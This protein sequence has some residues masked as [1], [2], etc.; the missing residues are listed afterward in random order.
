MNYR[1]KNTN[2]FITLILTHL[3]TL[4]RAAK[5]NFF[6]KNIDIIE[7]ANIQ[8][9]F[10][11]IDGITDHTH[12]LIDKTSNASYVLTKNTS[13][14]KQCPWC[15]NCSK[16][17]PKVHLSNIFRNVLV[18]VGFVKRKLIS[19]GFSQKSVEKRDLDSVS[20]NII[21]NAGVLSNYFGVASV[22]NIK[23]LKKS[24]NQAINAIRSSN[25]ANDIRTEHIVQEFEI[26]KKMQE[27]QIEIS[28]AHDFQIFAGLKLLLL[29]SRLK[30]MVLNLQ[31]TLLS[32]YQ[33]KDFILFSD[34]FDQAI[35]RQID[36]DK[37][38][39]LFRSNNISEL[40]K[41]PGHIRTQRDHFDLV[42][43]IEIPVI[44]YDEI[45]DVV[46][47]NHTSTTVRAYCP[48]DHYWVSIPL[49]KCSNYKENFY[50]GTRPCK[51]KNVYFPCYT[52]SNNIF[53]F[54]EDIECDINGD[55]KPRGQKEPP[56]ENITNVIRHGDRGTEGGRNSSEGKSKTLFLHNKDSLKCMDYIIEKTGP[57]KNITFKNSVLLNTRDLLMNNYSK[58]EYFHD[59]LEES[60][61]TIEQITNL[62]V[63]DSK[64][65]ETAFDRYLQA[66][67][68]ITD[69]IAILC[70]I[71]IFTFIIYKIGKCWCNRTKEIHPNTT[72]SSP[73]TVNINEGNKETVKSN[74][75]NNITAKVNATE[76]SCQ[77]ISENVSTGIQTD[78]SFLSGMTTLGTQTE[79]QEATKVIS[80]DTQTDLPEH[81]LK[82]PEKTDA[83]T[84]TQDSITNFGYSTNQ[85]NNLS[86]E[87][88]T[89]RLNS[90]PVN[91]S[92]TEPS[93]TTATI[94]EGANSIPEIN[95]G[96]LPG[97]SS[98]LIPEKNGENLMN[99]EHENRKPDDNRS[100]HITMSAIAQVNTLPDIT[101]P[102]P[103]GKPSEETQKAMF[104]YFQKWHN[105]CDKLA[106]EKNISMQK[107]IEDTALGAVSKN[108][109][110]KNVH[111][112]FNFEN[113]KQSKKVHKKAQNEHVNDKS[114]NKKTKKKS[115]LENNDSD[116][117]FYDDDYNY[118]TAESRAFY[119][120]ELNDFSSENDSSN[121]KVKEDDNWNDILDR[122]SIDT[123]DDRK[124]VSSYETLD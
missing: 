77:T 2:M 74:Q 29:T 108:S 48:N 65:L 61:L 89:D 54:Q 113:E 56:R 15:E 111:V 25:K 121:D 7:K 82:T 102:L 57:S 46:A 75:V 52:M 64:I 43:T 32:K 58:G 9:L 93:N 87:M 120:Q 106:I 124:S 70:M 123:D 18:D 73:I 13:A 21:I 122:V 60:R 16:Y 19:I 4:T 50:C 66:D 119:S 118:K 68:N 12:R 83:T 105:L 28:D 98:T 45:C 76:A 24:V 22:A 97:L 36:H 115:H 44:K 91:N 114:Y 101:S 5:V 59:L 14:C 37:E 51:Y 104:E 6:D 117:S 27:L 112:D 90:T 81:T 38:F 17:V 8:L 39:A 85:A 71:A 109:K 49:K 69:S 99:T 33:G 30:F 42:Q 107:V 79:L 103:T 67:M 63:N 11:T 26:I 53:L 78:T 100:G 23:E 92:A 84:S 41:F 10:S 40:R 94:P 47:V 88:N 20:D 1:Y 86:H 116:R 3:L 35:D 34:K 95:P 96:T 80:V 72:N 110:K 31:V 55:A 62:K